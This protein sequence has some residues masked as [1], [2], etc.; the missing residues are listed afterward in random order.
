M[1]KHIA[2]TSLLTLMVLF[3]IVV[4]YGI[5]YGVW[6]YFN[7]PYVPQPDDHQASENCVLVSTDG[8]V[9]SNT[10]GSHRYEVYGTTQGVFIYKC[11]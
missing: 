7:V 5:T 6:T 4:L 2:N 10:G 11:E 1:K 8:I 3:W 9:S